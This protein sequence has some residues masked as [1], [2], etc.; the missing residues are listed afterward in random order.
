VSGPGCGGFGFG[1]GSGYGW[2][3]L[4]GEGTGCGAGHGYGDG[5][6]GGGSGGGHDNGDGD[7]YGCG[8]SDGYG[9]GDGHGNGFR[10][11]DSH[12]D[13]SIN[14]AGAAR[15]T[16][17][18]ARKDGENMKVLVTTSKRGVFFGEMDGP[19][20][21]KSP[22]KLTGAQMCV[23]WSADTRGVHGLAS[24]GP[25]D[26]CRIGRPVGALMVNHVDSV[27]ECSE[28]AVEA[29]GRAPWSA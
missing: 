9:F 22:V 28:A 12:G 29:W 20:D 24:H 27:A 4:W 10:C 13:I 3:F 2:G 7:G 1:E 21:G 11:G 19:W 25:T 6:G 14:T 17:G 23:Y 15:I 16:A 26:G 8:Y 5:C 18:E